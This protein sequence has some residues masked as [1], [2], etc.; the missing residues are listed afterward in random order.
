M[1]GCLNTRLASSSFPLFYAAFFSPVSLCQMS[2]LFFL[3]DDL[4]G[5]FPFAVKVCYGCE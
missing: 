4:D 1:M 3:K 2:L 5:I